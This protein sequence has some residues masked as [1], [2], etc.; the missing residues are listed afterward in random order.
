[1]RL[2][3]LL[4]EIMLLGLLVLQPGAHGEDAPQPLAV[5]DAL[6]QRAF[7]TRIPTDVSPDSRW[8]AFTLEDPSRR[9]IRG[10]RRYQYHTR[11]GATV[12][13]DACDV[14]IVD[15]ETGVSRNL[16]AGRGTSWG[17]AWSPDGRHL[18]FYSDRDGRARLWV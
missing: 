16:T 11:T 2:K 6:G 17:P 14:C 3:R 13:A 9:Q 12:D 1:M 15:T 8:I 5:E 7:A 10:E 4:S 18:A